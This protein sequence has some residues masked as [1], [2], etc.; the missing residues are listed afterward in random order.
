MLLLGSSLIFFGSLF[1]GESV[2]GIFF[3]SCIRD[4]TLTPAYINPH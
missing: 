4:L 3:G 1:L 2:N